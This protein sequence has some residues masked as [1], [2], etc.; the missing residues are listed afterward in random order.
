VRV[1]LGLK[2]HSGWAALIALGVERGQFAVIER[3]RIELA[4]A[5]DIAWAK[6]PYH[7]AD[8]LPAAAARDLIGRAVAA[9]HRVALE[10]LRAAAAEVRT[11]AHELVACA[12][13]MPAPMPAWS[14]EE[15]LAVH[16]RMHKAEGVLFPDA[17]A[18]AAQSCGLD[19]LPVP[20]KHL[21]EQ[22]QMTL[23]APSDQ[24]RE[25]VARLGKTVG[26]PWGADQK[27]AA[28]AAMIALAA[29]GRRGQRKRRRVGSPG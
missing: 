21:S 17:L 13:L 26:A 18:H 10:Q 4:D 12:V 14:V 1:A 23:R 8:G 28:L 25:R 6:Q 27:N 3:R 16:I 2:A 9:V 24:L 5:A 22:A 19:L 7:A 29:Q 20:E 11:A 15:I